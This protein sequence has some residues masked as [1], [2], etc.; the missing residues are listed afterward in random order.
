[1]HVFYRIYIYINSDCMYNHT[2]RSLLISLKNVISRGLLFLC[3]VVVAESSGAA[4][5][6]PEYSL[7]F[8]QYSVPLYTYTSAAQR[9]TE[10]SSFDDP[11]P[12]IGRGKMRRNKK[13]A[14]K[15]RLFHPNL[16]RTLGS[17]A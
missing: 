16:N 2:R 5:K 13:T 17:E 1:M 6:I 8:E 4:L 12:V 10:S 3:V 15:E 7:S 9:Y 11:I 14:S